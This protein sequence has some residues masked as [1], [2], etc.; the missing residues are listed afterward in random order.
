[1]LAFLA[2]I[3]ILLPFAGYLLDG[4]DHG[5]VWL[6]VKYILGFIFAAIGLF[7]SIRFLGVWSVILFPAV[8]IV[9]LYVRKFRAKKND[10][11][12]LDSREVD[13]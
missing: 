12:P 5:D 3:F 6:G 4:K 8:L 7:V 1:M 11:G 10:S 9:G 13:I 2:A